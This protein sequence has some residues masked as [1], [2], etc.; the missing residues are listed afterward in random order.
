MS[1]ASRAIHRTL[2]VRSFRHTDAFVALCEADRE[3]VIA[4]RLYPRSMTAVVPPAPGDTFQNV[5]AQ[6]LA[7]KEDRVCYTGSWTARKG[8]DHIA[9]VMNQV[10]RDNPKVVFDVF[11]ASPDRPLVISAF[12]AAVRARVVVQPGMDPAAPP[13][14]ARGMLHVAVRRLALPR[15]WRVAS[16]LSRLLPG[17]AASSIMRGRRSSAVSAIERRCVQRSKGC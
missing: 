5:A 1:V 2:F 16:P 12:D 11:G 3:W 4:H 10:L 7:A 15:R 8:I 9:A 14:D 6:T 17:R 13:R